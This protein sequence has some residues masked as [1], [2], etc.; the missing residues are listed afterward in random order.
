MKPAYHI[1]ANSLLTGISAISVVFLLILVCSLKR[2]QSDIHKRS[3]IAD[4]ALLITSS[5]GFVFVVLSIFT[6]IFLW[7]FEAVINSPILKN[8]ITIVVMLFLHWG[9]FLYLRIRSGPSL[10]NNPILFGFSTVLILGGFF[11]NMLANSIGGEVAGNGSGFEQLIR[12]FG[13]ETRFTFYLPLWVI[14][15]IILLSLMNIILGIAAKKQASSTK[16]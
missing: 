1:I 15:V 14:V 6:G 11:T 3:F 12:F 8:K 7:P 2:S 13:V 5:I 9:M 10:W 16:I 4:R